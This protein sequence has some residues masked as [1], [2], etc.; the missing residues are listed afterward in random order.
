MLTRSLLFGVQA[1]DPGNS[2]MRSRFA[3]SG[4][5]AGKLSACSARRIDRSGESSSRRVASM[6]AA[7]SCW[8][9]AFA[10]VEHPAPF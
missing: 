7:F 3:R 10:L 6:N 8:Q 1:W 4:L 5:N 9:I 2:D